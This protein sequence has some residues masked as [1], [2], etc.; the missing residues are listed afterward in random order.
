M[1]EIKKAKTFKERYDSDPEFKAK[2]KKYI[3][4]K[5]LCDCGRDVQRVAMAAH[6]RSN[7][8]KRLVEQK[9]QNQN[10]DIEELVDRLVKA[11]LR[12]M[13]KDI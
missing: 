1:E 9:N 12:D 3:S 10:E 8:H 2:H 4:E 11:K 6:K 13:I 5:I 7:I